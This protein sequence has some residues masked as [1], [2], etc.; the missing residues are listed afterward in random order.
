[1][2][3]PM[4]KSQMRSRLTLLLIAAMF[5][6]SFGVAAF[7]RFSGWSP[8]QGRNF[9]ELLQ[10]PRDLGA[11]RLVGADGQP[12]PWS[13]EKNRWRMV[14]VPAPGCTRACSTMVDTLH[15]IWLSQGRRADR[16]DVLWFGELPSNA[17]RFRRLLAM[18]RDA[19]LVAALPEPSLADAPE[20]YLIDPSGFLAV[21]YR[22]GF[23]PNGLRKDLGKL[24]K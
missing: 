13:P 15:R 3:P 5:L 9:G 20:V 22:A 23:D 19:A 10:P 21:R 17:V 8:G 24:V 12:Y 6:S 11:L 18:R 1:M 7:L 4:P 16:I 2:T 14:V